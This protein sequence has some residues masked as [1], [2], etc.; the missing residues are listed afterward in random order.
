MVE[1]LVLRFYHPVGIHGRTGDEEPF[2]LGQ[3]LKACNRAWCEPNQ[4]NDA[5]LEHPLRNLQQPTTRVR[6]SC[7]LVDRQPC[8]CR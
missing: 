4:A 6:I 1:R 7:T 2:D 3:R 8:A 5:R